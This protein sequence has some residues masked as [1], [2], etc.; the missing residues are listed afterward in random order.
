VRFADGGAAREP[1]LFLGPL[2]SA[3][4][5]RRVRRGLPPAPLAEREL[6]WLR[7]EALAPAELS[8]LR[9]APGA[10][11]EAGAGGLS[12]LAIAPDE[13]RTLA[14]RAPGARCLL[15]ALEAAVAAAS[16]PSVMGIL[17]VTP[18]SFSDGGASLAPERAL[19]H[20]LALLAEGCEYLDVG[21]ESTRPGAEPVPAEVEAARVVPVL[22]ALARAGGGVL[23][24]DTR[25]ASVAAAAL[26][27]GAEIVNDVS[28]GLADPELL[29]C[30]AE[31]GAGVVL[32]H[33][34][35]EPRE[36]QEAPRY[37]D[38]VREVAAHLRAR[39]RAAWQAGVDPGR[40]ALDPGLGF[41]KLLEHN[42]ELLRAL[43]ELLSL[44][45]P[46]CVGA[47]R[48][49][50]LGRLSGQT[51]PR[52]RTSETGAAVSL[53]AYLG[54]SLHRVHEVAAARAALSV[55]HAVACR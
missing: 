52:A 41:G 23:S 3:L 26:E 25:K 2:A 50:F 54:A 31:R 40:I 47:S 43:P 53:A 49:S 28:A 34:R 38:V 21:G 45:L 10:V 27:A 16:P 7:A 44:G 5:P 51:E 11:L 29:P 35:G 18:D 20:G 14:R 12:R 1:E 36:M 37:D 33:M 13:L 4:E 8:D 6:L 30:A 32:M 19:A 9:R 55:V 15:A 24:I 39:A 48:K 46:L 42:L 17:N 22:A